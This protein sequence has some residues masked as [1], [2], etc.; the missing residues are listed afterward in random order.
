MPHDAHAPSADA[1]LKAH[2][3]LLYGRHGATFL[4]SDPICFPRRYRSDDD[5]E[6][7]G[8]LAAALAYGRVSQI[9]GSLGKLMAVMGPSPAAF[10]RGFDPTAGRRLLRGFV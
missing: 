1:E 7:V 10:V 3:E 9:Q 6:V 5:R 8:F 2:L 4:H